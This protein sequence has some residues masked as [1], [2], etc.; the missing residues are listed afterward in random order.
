M[1]VINERGLEILPVTPAI[2]AEVFNIDLG[3]QL[4]S[5]QSQ[6]IRQALIDYQV[7][8]FRDQQLDPSSLKAFASHFGKLHVHPGVRAL[9]GDCEVLRIHTDAN[10]HWV[11]GEHWHSDVSCD[12]EPPMGTVLYM[13]TVPATGGDTLFSSM[14]AAY[15]ALSPQFKALIEG[16]TATHDGGFGFKTRFTEQT[17]GKTEKLYPR[18]SHPVV[19]THPECGEKALFVNPGFTTRI[20]GLPADESEAILAFLHA[21]A[22]KPEFQVR[23]H[24]RPN[25]VAFW[26]NRC[27]QHRAI[28][29]YFPQVRSGYRVTIQGDRPF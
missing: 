18:H 25:S 11:S 4:T 8:F 20:D 16:L 13:H 22:Q 3:R 9:E 14:Y 17:P 2:G 26:D 19:R 21:H 29:D 5:G 12:A 27:T 10:S 23:F 7:L 1:Q 6:A 15:R 28:W 24:W